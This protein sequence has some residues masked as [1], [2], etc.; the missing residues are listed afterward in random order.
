MFELPNPNTQRFVSLVKLFR[1]REDESISFPPS[2][3]AFKYARP[4]RFVQRERVKE[5][6]LTIRTN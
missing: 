1:R 5:K 2:Q 3:F 6:E 4:L